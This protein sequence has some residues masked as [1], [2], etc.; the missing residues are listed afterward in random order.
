MAPLQLAGV[1]AQLAAGLERRI[2]GALGPRSRAEDEFDLDYEDA[3]HPLAELRKGI[4]VRHPEWGI[5]I[6]ARIRGRGTGLD[7]KVDI[8]FEGQ[9]RRTVVIRHADLEI[10]E[11]AGIEPFEDLPEPWDRMELE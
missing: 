7:R 5:G 8:L 10:V 9:N 2:T 4:C 1:V 11:D 3:A 6:V